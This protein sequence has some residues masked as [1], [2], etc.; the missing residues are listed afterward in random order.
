MTD[1][2]FIMDNGGLEKVLEQHQKVV[3]TG[4]ESLLLSSTNSFKFTIKLKQKGNEK[5]A[6]H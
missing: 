6:Y 1:L 4:R 5:R 3:E 2:L